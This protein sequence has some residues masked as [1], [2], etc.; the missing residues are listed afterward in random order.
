MD[1]KDC[2]T[3]AYEFVTHSDDAF[4]FKNGIQDIFK[5]HSMG[6]FPQPAFS[7]KDHWVIP[8][9]GVSEEMLAEIKALKEYQSHSEILPT[10][11]KLGRG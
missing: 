3:K 11:P 8:C 7:D 2:N 5:K 4:D 1:S 10:G 6:L 9:A